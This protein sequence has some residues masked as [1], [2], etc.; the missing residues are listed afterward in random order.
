MAK[1]DCILKSKKPTALLILFLSRCLQFF[2]FGFSFRHFIYLFTLWTKLIILA[3]E[4]VSKP[5]GSGLNIFVIFSMTVWRNEVQIRW[6]V[7]KTLLKTWESQG[8]LSNSVSLL[9]EIII[10]HHTY[11]FY[12]LKLELLPV[13]CRILNFYNFKRLPA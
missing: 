9:A 8:I 1:F 6:Q 12:R 10:F 13:N 7:F 11:T 3:M 4:V 5:S 2:Y